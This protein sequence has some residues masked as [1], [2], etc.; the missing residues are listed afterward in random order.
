MDLDEEVARK[1][2]AWQRETGATN[3]EVCKALCIS[4][5]TLRDRKA[6]AH[7]WRLFEVELLAKLM[8]VTLDELLGME[9]ENHS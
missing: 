9:Q 7:S 6:A 4:E 3:A 2:A 8:G 1:V 5:T